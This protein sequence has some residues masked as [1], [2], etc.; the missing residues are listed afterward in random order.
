MLSCENPHSTFHIRIQ[1]SMELIAVALSDPRGHPREHRRA[2][3]AVLDAGRRLGRRAR[4]RRSRRLRRRAERGRRSPPRADPIAII[5]GNHD[6]AA[7]GIEDGSN[8]NQVA[9]IAAALDVR[10][11]DTPTNREYLRELPAGPEAIDELD[12]DLPRRALR[13]RPLH[14]RW[15]RC[16]ARDRREWPQVCLFGHTHLPV[17]FHVAN[18]VFDGFVPEGTRRPTIELRPATRYLINAGSVGQPRDG[19]PRAAYGHLRLGAP[20][21]TPSG[22]VYPDRRRAAA[23]LERG[24]ASQPRESVRGGTVSADNTELG[25]HGSPDQRDADSTDSPESTGRGFRGFTGSMGRGFHAD[26]RI[27][28]TRIPRSAPRPFRDP[29]GRCRSA[30]SS[31]ETR[32]PAPRPCPSGRR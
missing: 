11:A 1:H 2:R 19:D 23:H 17:V 18:E 10:D 29:R 21:L 31:A 16:A 30:A 25:F 7:C 15:R 26:H 20:S 6:K 32:R 8:F 12:R 14:L 13:R 4:A 3:D 5:R 9:R 24:V 22:N 27:N 28:G